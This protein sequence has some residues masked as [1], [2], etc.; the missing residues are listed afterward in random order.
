MQTLE[1]VLSWGDEEI[2]VGTLAARGHRVLFEYAPSFLAAPL[3]ISPFKL[4]VRAGDQMELKIAGI[5]S[6][7]VRFV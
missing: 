4:P 5:G 1:A 7:S 2:P 6:A 3:P